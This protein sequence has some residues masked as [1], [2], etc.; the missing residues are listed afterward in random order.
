MVQ[1]GSPTTT[2]QGLKDALLNY[3]DKNILSTADVAMGRRLNA[4][5]SVKAVV[6][7]LSP[8]PAA[9][10]SPPPAA[11]PS[12]PP[13]AVPSPPP[14]AVP[15]PPPQAVPSPP[16]PKPIKGPCKNFKKDS[17]AYMKCMKAKGKGKGKG[18]NGG[19]RRLGKI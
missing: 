19:N 3:A 13:A 11:M 2:A 16:P 14:A 6:P 17:K 5:A 18:K 8:P 10:P 7:A 9:V 15:S 12:P 4:A 1:A